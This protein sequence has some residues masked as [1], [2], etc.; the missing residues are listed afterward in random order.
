MFHLFQ[1]KD[2]SLQDNSVEYVAPQ[3][4]QVTFLS[5]AVGPGGL[6][7][8]K[9][10]VFQLR[11]LFLHP[12]IVDHELIL[13]LRETLVKTAQSFVSML[14]KEKDEAPGHDIGSVYPFFHNGAVWSTSM[15]ILCLGLFLILS[16]GLCPVL[17][18][19]A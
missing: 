4:R 17:V 16:Q 5:W 7:Q 9:N 8:G 15:S 13:L 2:G 1:P 18:L 19:S 11:E 10:M 12:S 3:M 14:K 6:Q